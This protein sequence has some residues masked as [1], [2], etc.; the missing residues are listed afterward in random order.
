[1]GYI[2]RK[3]VQK[4]MRM[5]I[6]IEYWRIENPDCSYRVYLSRSFY[7]FFGNFVNFWIGGYHLSTAHAKRLLI[8]SI[9]SAFV[10]LFVFWVLPVRV[11]FFNKV[12]FAQKTWEVL[13]THEGLLAQNEGYY[14]GVFITLSVLLAIFLRYKI[15]IVG[16]PD[17]GLTKN[18]VPLGWFPA[19]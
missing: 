8:Q 13:H 10:R 2:F 18:W 4:I 5:F 12:P 11:H 17:S 14:K 15:A 16:A 6:V 1:M 7:F 9:F 19:R 3:N